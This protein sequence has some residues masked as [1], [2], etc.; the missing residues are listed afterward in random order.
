MVA[1]AC[2]LNDPSPLTEF[3]N[4]IRCLQW[5]QGTSDKDE[6]WSSH[7]SMLA[8][9]ECLARQVSQIVSSCVCNIIYCAC[10]HCRLQFMSLFE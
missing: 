5:K 4:A 2:D 1:Q 6:V 8:L 9:E 7:V 3:H 10:C